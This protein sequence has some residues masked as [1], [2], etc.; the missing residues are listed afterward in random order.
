MVRVGLL[1]ITPMILSGCVV[2]HVAGDV[3]EGT[4]KATGAVAA[5]AADKV[6]TSDEE[7]QKK[8]EKKNN[9]LALPPS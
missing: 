5:A 2:M 1:L 4:V 8:E 9:R 7:K 3:A 6:T